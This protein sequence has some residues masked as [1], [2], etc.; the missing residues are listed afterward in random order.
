MNVNSLACVRVKGGE[1]ECFR[2]NS[3]KRKGFIMSSWLSNIYMDSDEG[4]KNGDGED[5]RKIS[6]GGERMVI[7]WALLC[8]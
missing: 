8:R 5:G 6:R 2:I 1:F 7:T 4:S 3:G